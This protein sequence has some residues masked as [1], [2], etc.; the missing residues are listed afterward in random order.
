[1]KLQSPFYTLALGL[2]LLTLHSCAVDEGPF[3]KPTCEPE[4]PV[5]VSY[6][7]DIQSIFNSSCLSCHS[8]THPKLNLSACCS[9][10]ELTATGFSAPYINTSTPASSKLYKHMIGEL[11]I[12]PPS[13]ALPVHQTDKVLKW[14]EQ[15]AKNN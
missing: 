7:T 10:V 11:L 2:L 4:V 6:S 15:G 1:M 14:I 8:D 5:E 3:V 12:M 9:Y 13:G